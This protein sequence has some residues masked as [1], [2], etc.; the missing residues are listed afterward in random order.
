MRGVRSVG[1]RVKDFGVKGEEE[2]VEYY[3]R[4]A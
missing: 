1:G 2:C 3:L 4:Q